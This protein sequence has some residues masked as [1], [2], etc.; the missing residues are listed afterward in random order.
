MVFYEAS[1]GIVSS[2]YKRPLT[3]LLY[4]EDPHAVVFL[5]IRFPSGLHCMEEPQAV[6][7]VS[8]VGLVS[9]TGLLYIEDL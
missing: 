9:K 6:F 3:G 8:K 7:Y 2:M 5:Y 4:L 1:T